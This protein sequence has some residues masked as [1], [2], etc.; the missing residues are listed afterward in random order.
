MALGVRLGAPSEVLHCSRCG[1]VGKVWCGHSKLLEHW[2]HPVV[3]ALGVRLEPAPSEVLQ[4]VPSEVLHDGWYMVVSIT[5]A[6][7]E[8]ISCVEV[9]GDDVLD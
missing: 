3:E 5:L 7:L 6:V 4:V 2:G 8:W 1:Q 9:V